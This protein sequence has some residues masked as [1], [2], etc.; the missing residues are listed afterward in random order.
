MADI[1]TDDEN[2]TP[3]WVSLNSNLF[4]KDDETQ[5]LVFA[6]N[7]HVPNI[8]CIGCW[9]IEKTTTYNSRIWETMHGCNV[10]FGDRQNSI[11]NLI[12]RKT[13]AWQHVYS[14]WSLLVWNGIVSCSRSICGRIWW[15][16][17]TKRMSYPWQRVYQII[18]NRRNLLTLC[19]R[20]ASNNSGYG[21]ITLWAILRDI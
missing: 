18:S 20:Y 9:N 13:K 7:K 8:P 1:V 16:S 10:K 15:I 4:L 3:T 12:R 2:S 11:Q 5:N 14:T 19:M 21:K 17:H 6:I